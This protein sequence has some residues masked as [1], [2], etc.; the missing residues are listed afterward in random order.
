M[1]PLQVGGAV[2]RARY[3]FDPDLRYYARVAQARLVE[4]PSVEKVIRY[5]RITLAT[6]LCKTK[7]GKVVPSTEVEAQAW[8]DLD[9]DP[10]GFLRTA[11]VS[12]ADDGACSVKPG[13]MWVTFHR[14]S[15]PGGYQA[16]ATAT[17]TSE[18]PSWQGAVD[19]AYLPGLQSL[20]NGRFVWREEAFDL[21]T[22]Q[23]DVLDVLA[24]RY[25]QRV[26]EQELRRSVADWDRATSYESVRQAIYALRKL[27]PHGLSI[28]RGKQRSWTLTA[29]NS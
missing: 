8:V 15:R 17:P 16:I 27:L 10:T 1:P 25:G 6:P 26:S 29:D 28:P 11:Q 2:S 9:N 23:A 22:Q 24:R 5:V 13:W 12:V 14:P 21:P 4:F 18:K 19:A 3:P 7:G 20:G